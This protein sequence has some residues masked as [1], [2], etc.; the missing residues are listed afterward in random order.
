MRRLWDRENITKE[1]TG[2]ERSKLTSHA[3][4]VIEQH[5]ELFSSARRHFGSWSGALR[6]AGITQAPRKALAL[7]RSRLTMLHTPGCPGN[8]LKKGLP[9]NTKG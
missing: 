7:Y 1:N 8:G 2:H 9:Q 5:Q 4:Y 6:A 3:K